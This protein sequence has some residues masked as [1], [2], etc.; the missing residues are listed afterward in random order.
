[1]KWVGFQNCKWGKNPAFYVESFLSMATK[2]SRRDFLRILKTI[3]LSMFSCGPGL[4]MYGIFGEPAW[5]EVEQVEIVLPHLPK[6]FSGL[7]ILHIS[8]IHIG[9]WMN[10][11]RLSDVIELAK[12]QKPD[13]VVMT[14]DYVL[15]HSWTENLD[16]AAFD[17]VRG[18]MGINDVVDKKLAMIQLNEFDF[19]VV[20]S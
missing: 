17:F 12:R 15:G 14:G 2:L 13:L 5:L 10:R 7:R 18:C 1:V 20:E 4:L 16:D 9:G 11:A 8:D 6:S 19:L 3:F